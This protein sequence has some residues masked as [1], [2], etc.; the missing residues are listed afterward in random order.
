[1][2][3]RFKKALLGYKP[4]EIEEILNEENSNFEKA[5]KEY[6]KEL[7]ITAEENERLKEE[8]ES[9]KQSTASFKDSKKAVQ[10]M[11]YEA[12]IDTVK[13][14]YEAEKRFEGMVTEKSGVLQM[15][16]AKNESIKASVNRLVND[17]EAIVKD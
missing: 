6:S 9:I 12:H 7:T 11:L 8:L 3:K 16:K 14:L 10:D 13:L 15:Q 5:Y 17:V 1:M 2:D 4:K